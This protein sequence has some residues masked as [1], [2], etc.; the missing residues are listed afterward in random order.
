MPLPKVIYDCNQ[1]N[2]QN[3]FLN[4]HKNDDILDS[5][6]VEFTGFLDVPFVQIEHPFALERAQRM[7]VKK[8][9]NLIVPPRNLYIDQDGVAAQWFLPHPI[10]LSRM[11]E[12]EIKMLEN[13]FKK[14][15]RPLSDFSH[16]VC[17]AVADDPFKSEEDTYRDQVYLPEKLNQVLGFEWRIKE[18]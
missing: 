1:I 12:A 9:K 3:D 4:R 6:I 11:T 7:L 2:D 14:L 5:F 17:I 8:L 10:N 13:N 18:V 15:L 16:E